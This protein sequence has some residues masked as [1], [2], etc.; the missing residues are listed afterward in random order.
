MVRGGLFCTLFGAF[1]EASNGI[2]GAFEMTIFWRLLGI[3][4][5]I[6]GAS[7]SD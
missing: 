4:N 6:G 2:G 5:G 3:S 1:L 7:G